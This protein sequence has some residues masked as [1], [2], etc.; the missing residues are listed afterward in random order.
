M[1]YDNIDLS[2]K[3][4]FH[5]EIQKEYFLKLISDVENE[6]ETSVCFPPKDLIFNA[7]EK[8]SQDYPIVFSC[9]PRT[10]Q[11]LHELDIQVS[12]RIII[13]EPLGFF[14]FVKLSPRL[15][16]AFYLA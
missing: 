13:S 7:F 4:F 2:W 12:D 14:D 6:Y 10:R 15:P 1:L 9:H 8:I 16:F 3:S 11:R 5:D